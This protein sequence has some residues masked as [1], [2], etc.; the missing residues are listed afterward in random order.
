[1]LKNVATTQN[2][3]ILR[4]YTGKKGS[5]TTS[6]NTAAPSLRNSPRNMKQ[7]QRPRSKIGTQPAKAVRK[8][9]DRSSETALAPKQASLHDRRM[10]TTDLD[11]RAF[12]GSVPVQTQQHAVK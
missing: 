9:V 1:M 11:D 5:V 12:Y 7:G 6:A 4:P 10:T 8:S 3:I 2:G